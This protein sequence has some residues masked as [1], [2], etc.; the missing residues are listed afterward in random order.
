V[1][2]KVVLL[3]CLVVKNGTRKTFEKILKTG[4]KWPIMDGLQILR[5]LKKHIDSLLQTIVFIFFLTNKQTNKIDESKKI[6]LSKMLFSS[7]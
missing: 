1:P 6:V 4:L 2:S 3:A 5:C 7:M